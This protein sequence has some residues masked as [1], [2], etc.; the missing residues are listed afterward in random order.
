MNGGSAISEKRGTAQVE[1]AVTKSIIEC[2][3]DHLYFAR[4][5]SSEIQPSDSPD[6][7]PFLNFFSRYETDLSL[8]MMR[9]SCPLI[10]VLTM[11]SDST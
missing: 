11:I 8:R 10:G 3:K 6:S 7:M 9:M 2:G 5:D 4:R 1:I